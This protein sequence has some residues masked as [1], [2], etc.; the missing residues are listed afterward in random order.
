MRF[1]ANAI[2]LG[3]IENAMICG[4]ITDRECPANQFARDNNIWTDEIDF[5]EK[6]QLNLILKLKKLCPDIVIT[7]VHKILSPSVVDAFKGILI[8]LHYSLLPAFGG[9]IGTKPVRLALNYGARFIGTTVHLVN[10]LVDAG[11]P[12]VQAVI[13]VEKADTVE[14]VMDTVF[15]CGCISLLNCVEILRLTDPQGMR[16]S[17]SCLKIRGRTVFINPMVL[18]CSSYE[19]EIFWQELKSYPFSTSKKIIN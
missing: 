5:S 11:M 15:R 4:V 9:V 12:L 7:T 18:H 10:T 17:C 14:S 3:L 1:M 8:N 13:P 6:D 16:N 19:T 2:R